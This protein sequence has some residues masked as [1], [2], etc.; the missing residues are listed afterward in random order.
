MTQTQPAITVQWIKAQFDA[1]A[2][3]IDIYITE[4][5]AKVLEDLRAKTQ[6]LVN[7]GVLPR[8]ALWT[9]TD[10]WA[11]KEDAAAYA[12]MRPLIAAQM[13]ELE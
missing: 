6:Q 1:V 7:E 4:Y 9:V 5:Q 3:P 8:A 2:F 12:A 10:K 11:Q 13:A